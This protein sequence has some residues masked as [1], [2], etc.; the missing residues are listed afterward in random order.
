[1]Y[2]LKISQVFP[3]PQK[4]PGSSWLRMLRKNALTIILLA[5]VVMLYVS[6]DFKAQFIRLAMQTG[7]MGKPK[8]ETVATVTN[9][10]SIAHTKLRDQKGKTFT[11]GS[12][13]GKVVFINFWATWCAPCRAEMAGIASL[14]KQFAADTSVVFLMVDADHQLDKSTRFLQ[15][16]DWGLFLEAPTDDLPVPLVEV[17]G[18]VPAPLY[19]KS[20]PA[21]FV[22][23]REGQVVMRFYGAADYSHPSFLDAFRKF[24]N[25]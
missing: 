6:K 13:K 15:R 2:I 3:T 7:I 22:L 12:L 20:I 23:N 14:K 25:K 24:V 5:V 1:M 4:K 18:A 16:K 17:L 10:P 11:I 9:Q 19:S 8:I 21:S